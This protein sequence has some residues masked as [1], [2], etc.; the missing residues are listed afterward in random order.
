MQYAI[1]LFFD[2]EMEKKLC[3]SYYD[4]L[5]VSDSKRNT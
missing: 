1:E 5:H 2:E 4:K 3:F